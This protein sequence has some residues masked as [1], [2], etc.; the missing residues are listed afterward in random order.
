MIL[1]QN[2]L[3][4]FKKQKEGRSHWSLVNKG[5]MV[6]YGSNKYRQ[7]RLCW[8]SL[9]KVRNVDIRR[10]STGGFRQKSDMIGMEWNAVQQERKES[11]R[12]CCRN[13]EEKEENDGLHQE[14]Q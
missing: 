13:P 5:I 9:V 2:K 3:R 12:S 1:R 4:L 14:R 10:I 6:G 7:P 11:V 8:A